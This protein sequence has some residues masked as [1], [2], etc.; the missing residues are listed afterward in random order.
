MENVFLIAVID[1]N[2]NSKIVITAFTSLSNRPT[3]F[4][5]KLATQRAFAVAVAL[6]KLGVNVWMD[7]SGVGHFNN[8]TGKPS[9]RKAVITWFPN[10]R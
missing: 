6:R 7:Y 2:W 10:G 1:W 4:A 8:K 5:Q 9:H 3:S